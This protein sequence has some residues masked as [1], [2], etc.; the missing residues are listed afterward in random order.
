MHDNLIL[1]DF[2]GSLTAG[3]MTSIGAIPVPFLDV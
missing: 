1:L 3:L 2:L